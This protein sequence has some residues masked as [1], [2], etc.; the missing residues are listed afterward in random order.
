[1]MTTVTLP[2]ANLTEVS[3]IF[4]Y[5][6][7]N[8]LSLTQKNNQTLVGVMGVDVA[9]SEVEA[10]YSKQ[11]LGPLGYGYAINPNGFVVFHPRLQNQIAYIEVCLGLE[12]FGLN[13][14]N[15]LVEGSARP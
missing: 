3:P 15:V 13:L 7:K 2:V 14:F 8:N 12:V 10:Q 4:R 5:M 6:Y 11:I 9:L 1:M